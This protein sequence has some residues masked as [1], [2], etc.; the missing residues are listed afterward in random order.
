MKIDTLLTIMQ[1]STQSLTADEIV[2]RYNSSMSKEEWARVR[3]ATVSKLGKMRKQGLIIVIEE[4]PKRYA[5]T[6][7]GRVTKCHVS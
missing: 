4:T 7:D 2:G 1:G 6:D 5:L 3:Q